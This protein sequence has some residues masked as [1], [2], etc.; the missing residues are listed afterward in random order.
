MAILRLSVDRPVTTVMIFLSVGLLGLIS[1]TRIPQELFP[2]MEYPQIT[3]VT[4]YEGAGPEE[5]EKLISKMVEETAGTV[6]NIKRV[7]SNSKEGVSIV[8]CEFR[9]GTNM[10]FAAMDVREKIDL[11]KEALPRDSYEP[12]VLKYNPTQVEAMMLSVSY[13]NGDASPM[14]MAD[15]RQTAKK[16]IKDE[17]ERLEGVAKVELRGGE[18]KEIL[19]EIDKGRLLAN[20]VSI[21]EIIT[22]LQNSNIT[23]PAGTIKEDKHEYLV[24]TVGEFQGISD[25]ADL[26]F[27]KVDYN[28]DQAMSTKRVRNRGQETGDKIV[29]LR[30]IA[31]VKESLKDRKGYSRYQG[32]ENI[33]VGIYQQ[34]GS[35][36]INLSKEVKKKL[37][38]IRESNKISED[39]TVQITSDQSDF[40]KESLANL[41][42]SGIQGILLSFIL[43]YFFMRSFMASIIINIA[44]PVAL[45]TTLSLMY[46]QGISINTMSLGGLTVGIGMVVDNSNMVLENILMQYHRLKGTG[47]DKKD[48]IHAATSSLLAPVLS[49]TFTS[50]AIFIPFVFVAGMIGQ[51]FKQLALTITFSLIS[52]IFAAMF[53]VPRLALTADL[54]KQSVTAGL[55]AINKYFTP[56]FKRV[57]DWSM[58]KVALVLL[59]YVAAGALSFVLISKEFMPK[60]D[61]RRFVLNM[62]MPPDTPIE[63][64][65]ATSKRI[66]KLISGYPE[67]RDISVSVGSTGDDT[68]VA[69]IES[70]GTY[71]ARIIG[72]L[73][74]EG[75]STDELVADISN[76]IRKWNIKGIDTEFITQQGL[77][78][79]GV[80]ASSGLMIEIRGTELGILKKSA[81]EIRKIMEDMPQ[82]YGIKLDPPDEVPELR[83]VIDR[84]RASLF[85]LSTQDIS[86]MTLA[87]IKGFVATKLKLKDDEM[88]IRVRMRPEDR[89]RLD[90][91]LEMTAYSPWGMTIQI[92]QISQAN[93]VKTLPAIKRVEGERTYL[94]SSNVRGNFTKAVTSIEEILKER[95][96]NN[97]VHCVISGEM[98]AMKE[99]LSQI[100]FALGLGVI[101]IFMILASEFESL[102]QPVIVMT[103]VPL[104]VV[105]ALVSLF[106]TGQTINSI[107]MLGFIMLVGNVIN[108]SILLVDRFNLMID[109]EKEK[110]K[111]FLPDILTLKKKVVEVTVKHIR[112]ITMT[113]LTTVTGML[114]LAIGFGGK[115]STNQPM[116][117]AVVGGL[118]FALVLALIFVPYV[119]LATK[120]M[121]NREEY[122]LFNPMF[123]S[124]NEFD[125]PNF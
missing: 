113:T 81:D 5:A 22:S 23:Y 47:A 3:I 79:S 107:S 4:K 117:I 42:S 74:R 78:G 111:G 83:L 58:A 26:S 59:I 45:C 92:K 1:Y 67:V 101:I 71:Q 103:A 95:Y 17:L 54:S 119:Y 21:T 43:L 87:A 62:T 99:A 90:K 76:E 29:F 51:L 20:Q 6:K 125:E 13:A 121:R 73:N 14:A 80:G 65:N 93:F 66:E 24:K 15:L 85:G 56:L 16:S 25:V 19:V 97:D 35:N 69:S 40:I 7:S 8:T 108:I 32:N 123:A 91:I 89:D 105:G 112:P 48:S 2:A 50:V 68:G 104:G 102:Y 30:D 9:W 61:E 94:L 77:F 75:M 114:P 11:I 124:R 53:L 49:A 46:F 115:T 31:D 84:E 44:I 63:I 55:D 109:G 120:G 100:S 86:A 110:N 72:R 41:Y 39:I 116:A 34:S 37:V 10:D 12:V 106:V 52:S 118:S 122:E 98:L 33:S 57:L 27:S 88:D 28:I 82:F 38:E 96:D 60:V 64:T 70:L 18:E 36:L